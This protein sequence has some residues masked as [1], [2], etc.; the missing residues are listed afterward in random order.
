MHRL[1]AVVFDRGISSC[2]A[3]PVAGRYTPPRRTTCSEMPCCQGEQPPRGISSCT[4]RTRSAG[5]PNVF[6]QRH[7]TPG[8][9]KARALWR[10]RR[11]P[12]TAKDVPR[13][14]PGAMEAPSGRASAGRCSSGTHG[15]AGSV[16][17]FAKMGEMHRLTTFWQNGQAGQTRSTTSRRCAGGATERRRNAI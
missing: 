8:T 5:F 17:R 15:N 1:V 14:S 10:W 4:D 16:G 12:A 7:H 3:S 6:P 13:R 2:S 9:A 11:N